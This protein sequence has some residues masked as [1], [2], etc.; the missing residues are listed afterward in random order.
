MRTTNSVERVAVALEVLASR[1]DVVGVTRSRGLWTY[2]WDTDSGSEWPVAPPITLIGGTSGERGSIPTDA[3]VTTWPQ[4]R[5]PR[6]AGEAVSA[7]RSRAPGPNRTK[8]TKSLQRVRAGR[9]DVHAWG[10]SEFDS[11]RRRRTGIE[12]AAQLRPPTD[13]GEGVRRSRWLRSGS[14]GSRHR[15]IVKALEWLATV[16]PSLRCGVA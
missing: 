12:P 10:V 11:Q 3:L 1:A 4:E 13:L 16:E 6:F 8:G 15:R 7:A 14:F 9:R 5:P 2:R